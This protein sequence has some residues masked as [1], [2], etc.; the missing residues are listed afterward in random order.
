[1]V[2]ARTV[3]VSCASREAGNIGLYQSG[4]ARWLR[5]MTNDRVGRSCQLQ[6]E[7]KVQAGP[8]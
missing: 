6:A 1:M 2:R 3:E 7:G 8:R 4:L 5:T